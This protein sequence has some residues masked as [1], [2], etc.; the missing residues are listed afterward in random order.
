MPSLVRGGLAPL[1]ELPF[2]APSLL[3]AFAAQLVLR[4][5]RAELVVTGVV[6]ALLAL[7]IYAVAAGRPWAVVNTTCAALGLA[8]LASLALAALRRSGDER[9]DTLAALRPALILPAFVS[10]AHP[11]VYLTAVLWPTTYDHRMYAADWALGGP[12]SFTIARLTRSVPLLEPLCLVVYVC[13]PLA[14]ALVHAARQKRGLRS[15][16]ALVAFVAVTIVGYV[17]YNVVPVTG[18]GYVFADAFPLAPPDP[19]ALGDARAVALPMPRNC[20]PSLHS[21]WAL[22]VLW[23]ARPLA[24]AARVAATAFFAVTLLAT[25]ALGFHYVVDLVAAFPLTLAAQAWATRV[26][27]E[28]PRR[29]AMLA[30]GAM[31]LAWI[32]SVTW[33]DAMLALPAP[34]LWLVAAAIVAVS[35]RLERLV[36]DARDENAAPEREV[37]RT[38]PAAPWAATSVLFLLGVAGWLHEAILSN[39]LAPVAGSTPEL[40]VGSSLAILTAFALGAGVSLELQRKLGDASRIAAPAALL[41]AAWSWLAMAAV[42]VAVPGEAVLAGMAVLLALPA[43]LATGIAAPALAS[44]DASL[45]PQAPSTWLAPL[46]LGAAAGALLGGYAVLPSPRSNLL[47]VALYAVA[48]A[49]AVALAVRA[50][51]SEAGAS[52]TSGDARN[53]EPAAAI[54]ALLAAAV[55]GVALTIEGHLATAMLGDT[56]YAR[57]QVATLLLAG[58][59]SGLSL[60]RWLEGTRATAVEALLALAAAILVATALFDS[61]PGYFASFRGYIDAHQVMGEFSQHEFIRFACAAFLLLPTAAAAGAAM[62]L[63][64]A[65]GAAAR[66]VPSARLVPVVLLAGTGSAAL[67][68]FVLLP[69][70]GSRASLVGAA[71]V[72]LAAVIPLARRVAAG[73]AV[74]DDVGAVGLLGLTFLLATLDVGALATDSALTFRAGTASRVAA[75]EESIGSIASLHAPG[76]GGELRI[77]GLVRSSNDG[78]GAAAGAGVAKALVVGL[79]TGSAAGDLL[80]SGAGEVTVLESSAAARRVVLAQPSGVRLGERGVVVRSGD[81]RFR[82]RAEAATYDLIFVDEP[83]LSGPEAAAR[84]TSEFYTLAAARLAPGGVLLQQLAL[85]RL[86]PVALASILSSARTAFAHVA[87]VVSGNLATLRACAN[88][89]STPPPGGDRVLVDAAGVQELLETVART[90]EVP[91]ESLAS[92]DDDLFLRYQTPVSFRAAPDAVPESRTLLDSFA[93]EPAAAPPPA[94]R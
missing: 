3:G 56:V 38:G 86:S 15:S 2:F 63:P 53:R 44:R 79:G 58:L 87:V 33:L 22:L 61:A 7:P 25:V 36:Y 77:N 26:T 12:L 69:A 92:S 70:L 72:V 84:C 27:D 41:L 43:A 46:L 34:L 5:R 67:A 47:V 37:A 54:A 52:G 28:R 50:S 29:R 8:A 40:R 81:A 94:L 4:P 6:A 24:P 18:P 13:L 85:E 90:L 31:T 82:L 20:M 68:A 55:A 23:N 10:L 49:V 65:G 71:V 35:C 39:A 89:S 62:A 73:I 91:V 19:A 76:D 48:A 59:A 21:A 30:G 75:I 1:L 66:G 16:D 83:E 42:P 17:G 45:S 64:L 88:C 32:A 74:L 93:L 14:L 11:M 57:A 60:A 78:R 80:E 51:P 9:R